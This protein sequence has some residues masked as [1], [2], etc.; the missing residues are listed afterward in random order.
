MSNPQGYAA[1]FRSRMLIQ[2]T[3]RKIEFAKREHI[4]ASVDQ[5]P[6]HK[7]KTP[8]QRTIQLLKRHRDCMFADDA[9]YKPISIIITTLSAHAYNEEPSV[10]AAL[11]GILRGMD[12][13][14]ENRDGQSWV[15]NPVNPAENFADKWADEPKKEENFRRWLEQARRDF[16][17]YLRSSPFNSIPSPLRE[18]L[19]SDLVN[20]TLQAVLPAAA[21]SRHPLWRDLPKQIRRVA[22]RRQSNRFNVTALSQNHGPDRRKIGHLVDT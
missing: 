14:I 5:I 16:G 12:R 1:W 13:F 20:R 21:Y 6:D 15:A 18:N 8:L 19:G 9:D 2:L 3:E 4:T 17:T 7:V 10:S 11:Q 22:Q